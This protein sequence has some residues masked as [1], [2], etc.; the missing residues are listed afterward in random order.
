MYVQLYLRAPI[1]H[2][3]SSPFSA[4]QPRPLWALLFVLRA[5]HLLPGGGRGKNVWVGGCW[6]DL[7]EEELRYRLP[8]PPHFWPTTTQAIAFYLHTEYALLGK[9]YLEDEQCKVPENPAKVER[10]LKRGIN[11]NKGPKW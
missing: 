2:V 9:V 10:P 8:S 5:V 4:R 3:L 11:C 7:S 1:A 6:L